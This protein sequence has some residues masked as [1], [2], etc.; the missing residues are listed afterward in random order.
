MDYETNNNNDSDVTYQRLLYVQEQLNTSLEQ[1]EN[2]VS[3]YYTAV[4]TRTY[5]D[6]YI[7]A[8]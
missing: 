5:K 8:N 1:L 3:K 6:I 4:T 7:L 2:M